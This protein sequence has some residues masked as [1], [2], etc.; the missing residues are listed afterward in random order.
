MYTDIYFVVIFIPVI[1]RRR[2]V[3]M[4]F[5]RRITSSQL[6]AI[7]SWRFWFRHHHSQQRIIGLHVMLRPVLHRLRRHD[8]LSMTYGQ[9]PLSF[10]GVVWLPHTLFMSTATSTATLIPRPM[11][12][13]CKENSDLKC[14]MQKR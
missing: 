2:A 10:P 1:G 11:W 9:L 8:I 12:L 13:F 5:F 6:D 3:Q 7:G 4:L 14:V